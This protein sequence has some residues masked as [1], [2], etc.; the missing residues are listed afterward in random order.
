MP[1]NRA[2]Y[3]ENWEAIATAIKESTNWKCE[4][5]GKQ[6][7]RNGESWA[8][9][10]SDWNMQ[11]EYFADAIEHTQR[12]VLTVAHLDH[13]PE[14]CD[15]SN[16]KALCAPCHLRYDV[17]QMAMKKRLKREREGQ[18]TLITEDKPCS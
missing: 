7:R 2:L 1:M 5:C 15:R 6:C 10:F 13:I 9:F 16:L 17:G 12:F 8:E 4:Q 14:H 3:P 18:L 11:T